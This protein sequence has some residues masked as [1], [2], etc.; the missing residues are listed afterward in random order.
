MDCRSFRDNHLQFLDDALEPADLVAMQRHLAECAECARHD[1]AIRRGMLLLRN[2]P[3][4]EPSPEFQSRL[5]ARLKESRAR[6]LARATRDGMHRGPGL[7]VFAMTAAG[8]LATSLLA[9]V[10]LEWN[11][12]P[13]DLALPPVVAMA[14]VEPAPAL[15]S[16]AIVASVSAA[17]PIWPTALLVDQQPARLMEAQLR[18]VSWS[19]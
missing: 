14:P 1:T 11:R 16:P 4:I 13:H 9:T 12:P 18:M 5:A 10:T 17:M 6:D 3:T 8:V 15:A 7:G 19:R 2:M